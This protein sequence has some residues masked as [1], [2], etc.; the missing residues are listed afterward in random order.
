MSTISGSLVPHTRALR[1]RPVDG[2]TTT[3]SRR[4]VGSPFH[5]TPYSSAFSRNIENSS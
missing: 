1:L 5:G 4:T 3:V 2:S